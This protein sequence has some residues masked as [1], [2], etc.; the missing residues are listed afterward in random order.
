MEPLSNQ[1]CAGEGKGFIRL[2]TDRVREN[3]VDIMRRVMV[4][5][6]RILLQEAGE[7]FAAIIPLRE[8]ERLD[9]IMVELKP[10][11]YRPEEEEYYEGDIAIHCVYADE[12][13]E[14]FYEI[15][16]E[17]RIEGE[18]FGLLPPENLGGIEVDIFVPVAI[19]MSP[20]RFWVPEYILAEKRDMD[21]RC[22]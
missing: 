10:S 12:V 1:E 2:T 15:L 18:L 3:L 9:D 8:F 5:G 16:E 13:Q 19:L 21:E 17:V 6:E 4:E 11:Q 22:S 7:E 14:Y 20:D